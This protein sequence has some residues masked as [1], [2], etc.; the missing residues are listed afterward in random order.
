MRAT[1]K[2]Y[3]LNF[4]TPGGT[5]RGILTSKNTYILT[6]EKDERK[7]VGECALFE[8]LSCDDVPDY[9]ERLHWL[10]TNIAL[11][12]EQIHQYLENY[13]SLWIGY[14]QA[15]ANL[16]WGSDE[17][18]P[19]AFSRGQ[20]GIQINGLVWMGNRTYMERQIEEKLQNGFSCI[21]LKIGVDWQSEK[22]VIAMLRV[23][24]PASQLEIRVDAN[25]AF[26]K[27]N[28]EQVLDELSSLNIHSIEQP[29]KPGQSSL[30]YNLCRNTPV[31]I[32]LDEELIGNHSRKKEILDIVP[33]YI[34]LKPSLM[35]GFSGCDSWIDLAEKNKVGWWITS[36]LES[37][38]GLNAIA[39]YTYTKAPKMPQGLGT[40]GVFSNNFPSSLTLKQDILKKKI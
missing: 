28:V 9:E 18:F 10:A 3:T 12:P 38:V 16:N 15:M 34:I 11:E 23:R 22:Q 7:G 19:S 24:Y 21:K 27:N 35:G 39:Q 20:D 14:E 29:I 5:S 30:L 31:P 1:Y 36:A 17:Y 13:P 2:K 32:A 37:N 6:V 4:I 26:N 33:Q 8:G 25:G 40:G